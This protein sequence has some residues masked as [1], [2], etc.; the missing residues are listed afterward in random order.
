M[1]TTNRYCMGCSLE[2]M[3]GIA[4]NNDVF[5]ISYCDINR[6]TRQEEEKAMK[7]TKIEPV[8][9]LYRVLVKYTKDKEA[10]IMFFDEPVEVNYNF[11]CGSVT[12]DTI[13]KEGESRKCLFLT[14]YGL[15]DYC[16]VSADIPIILPIKE[17]K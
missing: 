15:I 10:I 11:L 17:E 14:H 9:P 2:P 8:K 6:M 16:Q 4:H 12:V 3:C 13:A 7:T 5:A 1:I